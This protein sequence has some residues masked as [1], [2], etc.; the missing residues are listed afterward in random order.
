MTSLVTIATTQMTD[1]SG[2]SVIV[3]EKGYTTFDF[4]MLLL[5]PIAKEKKNTDVQNKNEKEKCQG[6]KNKKGKKQQ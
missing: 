4:P 3:V 1:Y 5:T 6:E 2:A